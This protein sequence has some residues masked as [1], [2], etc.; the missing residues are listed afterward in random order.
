MLVGGLGG[1]VP[2]KLLNVPEGLEMFVLLVGG[3]RW[4]WLLVV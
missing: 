3:S 4:L 2:T 1:F